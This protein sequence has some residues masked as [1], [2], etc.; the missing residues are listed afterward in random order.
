MIIKQPVAEARANVEAAFKHILPAVLSEDKITYATIDNY[1]EKRYTNSE[2]KTDFSFDNI[3]AAIC[4]LHRE[5]QLAWKVKPRTQTDIARDSAA[6]NRKEV[7]ASGIGSAMRALTAQAAAFD[8]KE[9]Q[10][11]IERCVLF[12][13]TTRGQTHSK[14]ERIRHESAKELGRLLDLCSKNPSAKQAEEIEKKLH[15]F[16]Q[17]LH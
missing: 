1:L 8:R 5:N 7:D 12:V 2:G 4:Q 17:G 6:E 13:K 11:I 14:T 10:R 9:S 16:E 3:I 15:A